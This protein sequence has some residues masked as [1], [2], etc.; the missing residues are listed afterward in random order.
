MKIKQFKKS[1]NIGVII[2]YAISFIFLI[3]AFILHAIHTN[4][5]ADWKEQPAII[6]KIDE[7]YEIVTYTFIL[8]G[9]TYEVNSQIYS[10]SMRV[11]DP[12]VIYLNPNNFEDIYVPTQMTVGVIFYI[13][14]GVFVLM[15]ASLTILFIRRRKIHNKCISKGIKKNVAVDAFKTL[16]T[17]GVNYTFQMVVKYNGKE[18]L[19]EAFQVE[20]GIIS[21]VKGTVNLYLL[22]DKYYFIDLD[23]FSE[24]IDGIIE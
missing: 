16:Y 22:D 15:G 10:S 23:S 9:K 8:D 13:V 24:T 3:G 6:S 21:N 19:S 14:S 20:K 4:R 17:S 2:L 11:E 12:V 7:T 18:Y 1:N 5:L